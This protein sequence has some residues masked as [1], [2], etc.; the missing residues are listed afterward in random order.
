[1]IARFVQSSGSSLRRSSPLP[2]WIKP[3]YSLF[4]RFLGHSTV[5]DFDVDDDEWR[6]TSG[7]GHVHRGGR[8]TRRKTRPTRWHHPKR[9]SQGRQPFN[10]ILSFYLSFCNLYRASISFFHIAIIRFCSF[11]SFFCHLLLSV[12]QSFMSFSPSAYLFFSLTVHY[13][14]YING[15][16]LSIRQHRNS[17]CGT[18]TFTLLRNRWRLSLTSSPSLPDTCPNSTPSP[19]PVIICKK[20]AR[21][22]SWR[23]PSRSQM[24]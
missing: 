14:I 22:Q 21:T 4:F 5:E 13:G 7:F 24:E 17:W 10:L 19:F 16:R 3:D 8:R 11:L 12:F 1:M 18:L 9:Y 2:W 15:H 20:R 6:R 23:W